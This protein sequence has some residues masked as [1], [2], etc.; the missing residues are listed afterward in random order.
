MWLDKS[1][2]KAVSSVS[3]VTKKSLYSAVQ[4]GYTVPVAGALSCTV[5]DTSKWQSHIYIYM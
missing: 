5:L 3:P 2:G 1:E 4:F